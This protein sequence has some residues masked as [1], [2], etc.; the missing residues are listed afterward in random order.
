[1]VA[2]VFAFRIS[3]HAA[4]NGVS[5]FLGSMDEIWKRSSHCGEEKEWNLNKVDLLLLSWYC[6][7][8]P[9]RLCNAIDQETSLSIPIS[10][11]T[12]TSFRW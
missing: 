2:F 12:S 1:M 9:S 3:I 6:H 8:L 11:Y 5:L 10:A 4:S 7:F